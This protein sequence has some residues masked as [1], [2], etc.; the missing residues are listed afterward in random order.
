MRIN[1]EENAVAKRYEV[2]MEIAGP[3]LS[4][5]RIIWFRASRRGPPAV[6]REN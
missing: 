4:E 2:S 5:L 6:R 3:A 1:R